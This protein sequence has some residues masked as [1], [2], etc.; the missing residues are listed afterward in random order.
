MV[1][2]S[3]ESMIRDNRPLI[4]AENFIGGSG[5]DTYVGT[6]GPDTAKGQS[7]K[8]SLYG[9]EG[10]DTLEGGSHA[11][12]L[13]GGPGSIDMC[14]GNSGPDTASNLCDQKFSI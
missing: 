9:G 4:V 11:D 1:A 7:G 14:T 10:N 2:E 13:D 8:D 5:A 6:T 12:Y 3:S